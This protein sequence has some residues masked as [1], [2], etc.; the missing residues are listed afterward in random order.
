MPAPDSSF[1]Q[2]VSAIERRAAAEPDAALAQAR[3]ALA[4]PDEDHD[5]E[6][7]DA[8]NRL[9]MLF[10][11]QSLLEP[12][13]DAYRRALARVELRTPG[14][15]ASQANLHNNIGQ[16]LSALG[17]HDAAVPHLERALALHRQA[18]SSAVQVA[19]A[20]DNLGAALAAAGRAAEAVALHA[21]ALDTFELSLGPINEHAATALG[22]LGAAC[23]RQGEP[24]RALACHLR[25]LDMH[26][27]LRGMKSAGALVS[28]A[29]LVQ[30]ALSRNDLA[31]AGDLCDVLV[32]LAQD[33]GAA[34]H[35]AAV[36]LLQV[37]GHAFDA[38]NLG[39]ADRLCG[40]VLDLLARIDAPDTLAKALQLAGKVA[41]AK[42]H[43]TRAEQLQLSLLAMPGRELRAQVR[44][45]VEHGKNLR[46]RGVQGARQAIGHFEHALALL[47]GVADATPSEQAH[48]LGNLAEAQFRADLLDAADA[49]FGAALAALGRRGPAEDRAWLSHAHGLL[50]FRRGRHADAQACLARA[51]RLWT[52]LRGAWHPFVATACANLA[53]VHW[54]AGEHAAA[55]RLLVRAERLRAP[56]LARRLAIG[57]DSERLET[58]RSSIGDLYRAVSFHFATGRA[59]PLATRLVL[60]FKGAVQLATMRSLARMRATLAPAAQAQLDRLAQLQQQ[61]TALIAAEQLH[62][63]R[64]DLQALAPLQAEAAQLQRVLG[65]RSARGQAALTQVQPEAVRAALPAGALLVEYL[66]WAQFE[67]RT[68]APLGDRYA[69]LLLRRRGKP[70]WVDLGA[71]PAIDAAVHA[72]RRALHDNTPLAEPEQQL[73]QSILTPIAATLA[74]VRQ[75]IV[76]PDGALNLLPFAS[77]LEALL[78]HDTLVHQVACGAELIDDP[79][80]A[81]AGEPVAIVDPEFGGGRW[82]ALPG[83]REEGALLRRLWP[84]TEVHAGADARADVLLGLRQPALLHIATHGHFIA[85]AGDRPIV[86]NT[87]FVTDEGVFV[88]Q[89]PQRSAR[90]DAMWHGGLALAGGVTVSAAELAQL[91][92]RSTA[93]VVLS[94]CD[95]GVGSTGLA[96]EFA[97]LRRAFAIAGARSQLT[98]LWAVEDEATALLMNEFYAGLRAGRPRAVALRDAQRALRARPSWSHPFYWAAFVLWGDAGPLPAGLVKENTA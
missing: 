64:V 21:Q 94:A 92:L 42:G 66:R 88:V 23:A 30:A 98:S 70:Q 45:W 96:Q 73:A 79:A 15:Q 54:D 41:L 48:V 35:A 56:E 5:P 91:D 90:D 61:I 67:P 38:F 71:A 76:A 10:F 28:T 81:A 89:S 46:E 36:A 55:Q 47:R 85:P 6:R 12:A 80:P 59:E 84:A 32:A 24:A 72:L 52:R 27:A 82:E 37:A 31:L 22:N 2:R 58:A 49:S 13:L 11:H 77:L 95:T 19:I 75:L 40:A 33:D 29:N 7:S 74:D 93:L 69:A 4:E 8:L 83:T 78:P 62:D 50:H 97:G 18:G 51:L 14:D 60:Q 17:R 1:A 44:D 34:G 25:S 39:L 16:A 68:Q 53:L 86:R 20:Q 63:S 57:S 26:L 9:G 87:S 65:N 43:T 3:A